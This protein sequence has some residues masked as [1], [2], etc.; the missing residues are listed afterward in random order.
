[1]ANKPKQATVKKTVGRGNM[2]PIQTTKKVKVP[3]YKQP[4]GYK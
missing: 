2:K 3:A 1:M 4:K